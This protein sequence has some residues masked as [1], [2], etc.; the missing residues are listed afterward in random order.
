MNILANEKWT[1][2]NFDNKIN[3]FENKTTFLVLKFR[4]LVKKLHFL[5][6]LSLSIFFKYMKPS[7]NWFDDF[8][9]SVKSSKLDI[10][11]SK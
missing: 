8:H 9:E 5:F 1:I 3:R 7:K 4:T 11:E 2:I 6:I 10:D